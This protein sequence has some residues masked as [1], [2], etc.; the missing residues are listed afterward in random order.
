VEGHFRLLAP[1]TV[2][3]E[4]GPY[5]RLKPLII[6]PVVSY[7]TYLGGTGIGS[8]TGVAVDALGNL[9]V[10][11]WTEALDFPTVGAV[12]SVNKGSVDAFVLKLNAAG[13]SVVYSTYIGGRSDDRAAA[14]AVDSSGQAYVTGYTTSTNFPIVSAARSALGG[15]RNAF[16]LKLN[17]A[18]STLVYS[19]Y[20]G[21][22]NY[23]MGNAIALDAA[24]EAYI[25]GDT[26]S[27]NFPLSHPVQSS[28]GGQ[29]DAFI[30]K[31]TTGGAISF[32]TFL[33]GSNTEH[34]GGIAVDSSGNV[35]VAGGTASTNF[36]IAGAIQAALG[37]GQNGFVTKINTSSSTLIYSTYLGGNGGSPATPEQA[38]A[39][40]VDASGS[41]YVA[42]VTN[43]TNFPVTSSAF[44]PAYDGAQDAFLTKINAAGNALVYSTYLGGSS[45]DWANGI[46]VDSSGN[47]YVGGYTLSADFPTD[48]GVQ[49]AL[50]G[51][52][53]AF[54]TKLNPAGSGLV[55]STYYGGTRSDTA[56]ALAIDSS[57]NIFVG[58]QTSSFDLPLQGAI[59]TTN[60]G[61]S[62]GWV[63]RLGFVTPPPPSPQAVSVTPAAGT[64]SSQTFTFVFSDPNGA[65]DLTSLQALFN[66]SSSNVSACNIS[67]DPVHSTFSL[68]NNAGSSFSTPLNLGSSGTLTNSQCTVSGVGSG[69][70]PSGNTLTLTLAVSFEAA[71]N[72]AQDIYGYGQSAEG[73]NSGFVQLGTY[74]VFVS[75]PAQTP[76]AVSVTPSAGTGSSQTF[77]FVFSDGSGAAD[78]S[79][80]F[81]GFGTSIW[82]TNS[83]FLQLDSTH[84]LVSLTNDTTSAWMTPIT[85][86][87]SATTQ[88]SQC[89]LSGA[90]SSA[91]ASGGTL[92]LNLGLTF[93]AAFAGAKNI[94]AYVASAEGL[95]SSW[96]TLGTYTVSAAA[97]L[98]VAPVFTPVAGTFSSAQSVTITSSTGGAS[99]RYTTNGSTPTET[100]GTQYSA[101]FT[102]G[103]SEAIKAIAYETGMTDSAVVSAAYTISSPA[104][105]SP[106]FTPVAGTYSSGQSVSFTTS[107]AGASIRYTTNGST[108]T[109]TVG[110]LY[111]GPVTV[112]SSETIMAIAYETGM[113][114]STVA[115]A[116]YTIS[117]PVVASPAFT[118]VAGTYS[119]A[120]SVSITTSTAG[121]SIRYTTNGS[122]PTETVGTLYS[123]PFTVSSSETIM[124]IAYETGM[125]DSAVVSAAYTINIPIP[126]NSAQF[127]KTDLTTQGSWTG[128]YGSSGYNVIDGTTVYPSDVTVTPS[129]QSNYVWDASTTDVRALQVAPS[130]TSR[131]AATWDTYTSFNI[132]MVFSDTAEH[133][134]AIYC[135]D[136]DRLS[137]TQTLSIRDGTSNAVLDSRSVTNFGNGLYLVWKVSG[138]VIVQ[139]ANTGPNA[140]V[141][142]L[143]FDP[144][145]TISTT[146][147]A[148]AFAPPPGTYSSAQS[149]GITTTTTG[150]S[151]RYTTDGSTPTETVGTLYNAPFTVSSSETIRAIAYEP[152]MTDSAVVSAAYT[153]NIATPT[154]SAQ[155]VK[156]DLTTQGT[157]TGVYGSIGYNV[158]DGGTAYPSDLTVTPSSESNYVWANPTTDVRA[159]QLGP[160]STT[161]IAAT[162]DTYTSFNIDMLFSDAAQHQLAIYCLDWD[163]LSRS[164]TISILDGTSSAV[165]DSRSI[166]SFGN[167]LYL[168]WKISGHVIVR[169]TN[170]GPNAVISG[171]FLD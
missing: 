98:V 152:G 46:A 54:I 87:S 108:P 31:L 65:A 75:S 93:P 21:G 59:Q 113:T 15:T 130:S 111:S 90:L 83:C 154:N 12:Q 67:V 20:L 162:W 160:S 118:P 49:D 132:D 30:T 168:V 164:Q 70:T 81:V 36:P 71:F 157:W 141:S 50:A 55:Y 133:Q 99:I 82:G 63:M 140:V 9:Y 126:A 39:I 26:Y 136:W 44:Q 47:A 5:D 148:P 96:Q 33:G 147:T 156:T 80:I 45:F 16:A 135:L 64:G 112:S 8:I 78:I 158:I 103:S 144:G 18:G 125:T 69:V 107:T 150:A 68:A 42:G 166:T 74:T 139:V 14:I 28:L 3:F 11:G 127:V 66:T 120:P 100:I 22:S 60:N 23:D 43:S 32:S 52:Y 10:A 109:E 29:S 138:H 2:G 153:I 56:N 159:L 123:G 79:S 161:R 34:A 4:L 116:A 84:T 124:A 134:L 91:S 19:T 155:F 13:T 41:A 131:I 76:Q 106:A 146:V 149:V 37:G 58:G 88:N 72:G 25:A 61:G 73:L 1:H 165:L 171:L 145:A 38:N 40:A 128:V 95:N 117:L 151:I 48:G 142:G 35:Y 94:Y 89:T 104:V 121:A 51:M 92:T 119:S 57:G 169:V 24:G 122:T 27:T 105:A 143:F 86:G 170:T 62:T 110:T 167:G 7:C 97:G 137:R 85:L 101:S 77:S 6:D 102:V 129:N 115:S 163:R 17:P 114:D 53:D